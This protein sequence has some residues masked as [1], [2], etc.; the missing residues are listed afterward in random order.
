MLSELPPP[1]PPPQEISNVVENILYDVI[2]FLKAGQ[3]CEAVAGSNCFMIGTTRQ[4]ADI[5]GN[6]VDP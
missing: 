3:S 6:L 5:N 1:P 4:I 2:I